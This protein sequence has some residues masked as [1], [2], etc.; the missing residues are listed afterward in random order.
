MFGF[1]QSVGYPAFIGIEN[2][3]SLN[4][5]LRASLREA[6]MKFVRRIE[7]NPQYPYI[8]LVI[9]G[10]DQPTVDFQNEKRRQLFAKWFPVARR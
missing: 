4:F 2:V 5:K 1:I 7:L 6:F 3:S 10:R 9:G 8:P